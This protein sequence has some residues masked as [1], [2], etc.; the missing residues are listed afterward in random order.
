M[1]FMVGVPFW[2]G[3]RRGSGAAGCFVFAISSTSGASVGH[4]RDQLVE[5]PLAAELRTSYG[6]L[7]VSP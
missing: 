3:R 1:C 4:G 2:T 5:H 7:Y 6:K